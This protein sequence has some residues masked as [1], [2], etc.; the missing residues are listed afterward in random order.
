[1]VLKTPRA[2]LQNKWRRGV[3]KECTA[4]YMR[5]SNKNDKLTTVRLW[6]LTADINRRL[7][8][9]TERDGTLQHVS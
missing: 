5:M 6:W 3:A 1:M 2:S 8:K 4:H 7:W 9:K